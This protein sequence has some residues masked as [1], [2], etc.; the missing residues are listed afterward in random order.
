MTNRSA[1]GGTSMSQS[2]KE[3]NMR[4]LTLAL[5]AIAAAATAIPAHAVVRGSASVAVY[6]IGGGQCLYFQGSRY[7]IAPC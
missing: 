4:K 2:T 7:W 6:P 1:T 5:A 3:T